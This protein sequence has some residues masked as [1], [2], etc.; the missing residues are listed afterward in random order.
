MHQVHWEIKG[1]F[2]KR[3]VLANVPSLVDVPDIFVFF[4]I[5]GRGGGGGQFF[6]F[7]AEMSTKP[8][9]GFRSGRTCERPLVPV[10][11]PGEH[12]PKPPFWKPPF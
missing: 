1:R 2:P 7:G 5:L 4:F 9:S 12:L 3:V 10:F 8:R 6:F 11:F